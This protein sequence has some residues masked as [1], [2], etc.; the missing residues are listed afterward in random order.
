MIENLLQFDQSLFY[1][2]NGLLNLNGQCDSVIKFISTYTVYIVPILL[3]M[4]WFFV[5]DNTR[6]KML[7]ATI[8]SVILWQ[9]PTRIIAW[10][11]YRPRP[12]TELTN[13]KEVIFHVPSYSFP[14]DHAMFTIALVTYLYLSGYKKVAI[15]GYIGVF[16]VGMTRIIAGLHYP[17]DI[18]AGWIL[19]AIGAWLIHKYLDKFLIKYISKPLLKLAKFLKLA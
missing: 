5:K 8:V 2:L 10:I 13:V 3:L 18:L 12:Y 1:A 11:W 15:W 6:I 19:G 7:N 16:L 4:V 14:S 17:F 9:I